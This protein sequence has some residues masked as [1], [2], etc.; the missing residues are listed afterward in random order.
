MTQVLL[1][2]ANMVALKTV[3]IQ[4]AISLISK[5]AVDVVASDPDRKLRS[6]SVT[7]EFPLV[8]RLRYYTN[9]PKRKA[10][11]S[12]R[13]V[14]SRDNYTCVYCGSKLS[15]ED[16]TVDHIMPR[17]TCQK[18][19]IQASTWTNTACSCPKCNRRKANRSLRDSGMKFH[20]PNFEPKI[21][22]TNYIVA[23]GEIPDVW[24]VYLQI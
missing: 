2:N 11:W 8:L 7:W 13:G 3:S 1:L 21:P 20:D 17:E 14:F 5:G 16:A 15:R 24:R 4:R 23:S 18:M 10:I 19:K 6:P 22:R 9:V 12:R